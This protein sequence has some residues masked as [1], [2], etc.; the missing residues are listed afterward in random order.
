MKTLS[1][2]AKL[3]P[4]LVDRGAPGNTDQSMP[5]HGATEVLADFL[6]VEANLEAALFGSPE[7]HRLH[8]EAARLRAE[9]ERLVEE[10]HDRGLPEV[11]P[12]PAPQEQR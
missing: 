10:A 11:P 5:H 7:A 9:Y 4:I 8:A 12:F 6:A 2:N 1:R 3:E